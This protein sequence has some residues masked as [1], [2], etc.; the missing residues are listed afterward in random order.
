MAAVRNLFAVKVSNHVP[1][2]EAGAGSRSVRGNA[3]DQSSSLLRQVESFGQFRSHRLHV[4]PKV[5]TDNSALLV[6]P[7]HDIARDIHGDC[8]TDAHAPT[9]AA[10]DKGIDSD[11][12]A[13]SIYQRSARV[14]G[15][16]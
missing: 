16:N 5:T 3:S 15:I 9:G 2:P 6:N 4:N 10:Q 7:I 13:F 12:P 14:P 1:L 11:Q 8:K